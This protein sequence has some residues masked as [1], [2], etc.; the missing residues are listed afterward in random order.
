VA[1]AALNGHVVLVGND[2]L[3]VRVLL[4]L[5]EFGVP[6]IAVSAQSD[7]SYAEAARATQVA[8]VVGDLQDEKTLRE[9]HVEGARACALL[10][11]GDLANLHLAL[12]AR[13]LA[14]EAKLVLR[15]LDTSLAGPIRELVGDVVVL[16]ASELAA[17]VFVEAALRGSADLAFRVGDR[18]VALQEVDTV[19]PRPRLALAKAENGDGAP[20]LFP[21]EA[22]RVLAIVDQGQVG[23]APPDPWAGGALEM[24]IAARQAGLA[25]AA[26]RAYR[27][28][29]LIARGLIG[30]MDRRLAVVAVLFVLVV[31]GSALVFDNGLGVDLLD[32]F[33]FTVT[34]VM[35]V[36]YGDISLL[37]ASPGIK[38]FGTAI[39]V[40]GGLV[41]ALVFALLTDAIV[42]ARLAQALGHGPLPKRDHVIVC[43]IGQTGGRIVEDLVKADVPCVAV[44]RD[45]GGGNSALLRRLGVP[46]I[47]GDAASGETLDSLRLDSAQA[48]MAMTNDDLAN[49]QCALLARARAPQLRVVLRLFDH[50]L[51]VRV[52]RATDLDL[53][54]SVSA[55]AAPAFV[56]AILGRRATAML[57]VGAELMQ[58]VGLTAERSGDV[59]TLENDRAARVLAVDGTAFPRPDT[60]FAKGS[61]LVLVGTT[62]GLTE[63]ERRL[64]RSALTTA[65]ATSDRE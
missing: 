11:S 2:D 25:A 10:A 60:R 29:W 38:L 23:P 14:P 62:G 20:E 18:Q 27:A 52:Q 8:L 33:Y 45:D 43:G 12:E 65:G 28:S 30:V 55:L 50:E 57:P 21:T 9:A 44:E 54:R 1:A 47:L 58:V 7:S 19:D 34:T 13:E 22:T 59:R 64:T 15:L 53:S 48:L 6:T 63:L 35:S 3:G 36:G 40:L 39:M 61:E 24:R 51:A 5:H 26:A 42:G 32:A 49:L 31:M 56:A 4:E 16:S 41:L 37:D 46:L 17:P